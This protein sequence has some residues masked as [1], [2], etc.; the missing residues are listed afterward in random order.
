MEVRACRPG[1]KEDDILQHF[2]KE[3]LWVDKPLEMFYC[4]R[5]LRTKKFDKC[6][7]WTFP[8]HVNLLKPLGTSPVKTNIHSAF[9][10]LIKHCLTMGFFPKLIKFVNIEYYLFLETHC[11]N[12]DR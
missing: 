9:L 1:E 5:I 7:S 6:P 2:S 4:K 11:G 10:L 8:L 12:V 3:V